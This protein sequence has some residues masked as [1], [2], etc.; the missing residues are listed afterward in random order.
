MCVCVCLQIAINYDP[1][2]SQW[3]LHARLTEFPQPSS[4]SLGHL[5]SRIRA[6][7]AV[8]QTNITKIKISF[9]L[10]AIANDSNKAIQHKSS[11]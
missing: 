3:Q 8:F 11:Q 6:V 4:L 7:S 1:A 9:Q 10:I 5:A 2:M